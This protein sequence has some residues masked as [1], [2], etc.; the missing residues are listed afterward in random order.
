[1]QFFSFSSFSCVSWTASSCIYR[2]RYWTWEPYRNIKCGQQ[3]LIRYIISRA[4]FATRIAKLS[5]SGD[6]LPQRYRGSRHCGGAIHILGQSQ[7]HSQHL[8]CSP[9][10]LASPFRGRIGRREMWP[11]HNSALRELTTMLFSRAEVR[12]WGV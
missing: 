12:G 7:A 4:F 10:R 5:R 11:N 6:R 3:L 8:I 9:R 2:N 1:M